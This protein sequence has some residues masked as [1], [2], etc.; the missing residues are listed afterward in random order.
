MFVC[1]PRNFYFVLCS[2][3]YYVLLS[4]QCF[5]ALNLFNVD[6]VVIGLQF[7]CININ[8]KLYV[9][10]VSVCLPVCQTMSSPSEDE[11]RW[12]QLF[13]SIEGLSKDL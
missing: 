9:I 13:A 12:S 11:D 6:S 3:D 8:N 7:K 1:A 5:I 2:Y 4:V 10:V